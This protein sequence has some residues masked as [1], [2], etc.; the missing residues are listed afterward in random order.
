MISQTELESALQNLPRDQ[1]VNLGVGDPKRRGWFRAQ[2][3]SHDAAAGRLVLKCFMDRPT[4]RPL[5]PGQQ[6]VVAALRMD[7]ELQSAD[8][9]VEECSEGPESLVYLHM[10]GTW[11]P[12]DERRHQ[13]RV[14]VRIHS[15][16]SRRWVGGAWRD[17]DATVVDLS[18]RGVGLSLDQEVRVG[19][20][21][22]LSV[23]LADGK[24][25]LR[26]TVEIRHVRCDTKKDEP[27]SPLWRAG[28]LFRNLAP[29]DHERVIRFIFAEL[30]T[31]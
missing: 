10:A 13:V 9:D 31:R 5:E 15:N 27:A 8:M 17:L 18:S 21:V 19:D 25:D 3:V 11:Q 4:D 20:R 23:P 16:R 2:V 24:P 7:D 22:S 30:R 12:E 29:I 28:G 26:S 14:P 1:R 6:V